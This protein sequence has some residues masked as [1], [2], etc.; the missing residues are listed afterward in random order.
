MSFLTKDL[1]NKNIAQVSGFVVYHCN[2]YFTTTSPKLVRISFF[3]TDHLEENQSLPDI[4]NYMVFTIV[5][6]LTHTGV[7]FYLLRSFQ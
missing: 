7:D 6:I 5:T 1:K 2:V 3:I 4:F